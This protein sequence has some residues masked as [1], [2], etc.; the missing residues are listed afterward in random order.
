[1]EGGGSKLVMMKKWCKASESKIKDKGI[2]EFKIIYKS[3]VFTKLIKTLK[4]AS[5]I[6]LRIDNLIKT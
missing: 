3:D 4:F 6:F 1:M 2:Q 5:K